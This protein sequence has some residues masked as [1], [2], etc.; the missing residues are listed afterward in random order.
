M[1]LVFT[2]V[3]IAFPWANFSFV[4]SSTGREMMCGRCWRM[5]RGT[6]CRR[7]SNKWRK[8][9]P[10]QLC[11]LVYNPI[12]ISTNNYI[13]IITI[14][15]YIIIYI[16]IT[17]PGIQNHY[18][19]NGGSLTTMFKPKPR[20]V[21]HLGVS[22]RFGPSNHR[23]MIVVSPFIFWRCL[24]RGFHIPPGFCFGRRVLHLEGQC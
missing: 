24:S 4:R 17:Y 15:I 1:H 9:V 2:Y 14:Y 10:P 21:V 3:W 6:V 8:V 5:L 22:A 20:M 23:D 19:H 13:Y 7:W 16:Y 18:C 11:L 12:C